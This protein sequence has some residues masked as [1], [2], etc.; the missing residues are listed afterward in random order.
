M[1]APFGFGAQKSAKKFTH[2]GVL[3]G[4]KLSQNRLPKISDPGSPPLIQD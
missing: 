2:A 3:S 4:H 1:P